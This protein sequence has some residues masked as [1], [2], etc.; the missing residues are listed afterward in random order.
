MQCYY[1]DKIDIIVSILDIANG[2][3]VK[4]AE[5]L[6]KANIPYKL[7]KEYLFFLYQC[8]LIKIEYMR[9]QRTYKTTVKG[10]HFLST[11]NKMKTLI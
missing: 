4:Q 11:C 6:N 3:E 1:R 5:I 2:N 7:F 10:I 8:G 9:L